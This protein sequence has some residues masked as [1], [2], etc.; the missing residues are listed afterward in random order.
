MRSADLR[1]LRAPI[2][3]R[4]REAPETAMVTLFA[5]GTL[6]EGVACSVRTGHAPAEAGL[7]PAT[8][9]CWSAQSDWSATIAVRSWSSWV[10]RRA[11]TRLQS[12]V[13]QI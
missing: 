10:S 9:A 5:A 8:G 11:A 3:E 7:H 2:K 13:W 6:G 12:S 1:A 4:Y